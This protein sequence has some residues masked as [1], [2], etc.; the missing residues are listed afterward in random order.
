MQSPCEFE[1]TILT[2][3]LDHAVTSIASGTLHN[4]ATTTSG[5]ILSWGSTLD[6]ALGLGDPRRLSPGSP[7]G[8]DNDEELRIARRNYQYDPPP[9]VEIPTE[10]KFDFG[11]PGGP[12]KF[13]FGIG[14][15]G[16]HSAALVFDLSDR[17]DAQCEVDAPDWDGSEW[18]RSRIFV[19]SRNAV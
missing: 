8:F 10:I 11:Q 5:K 17:D 19:P 1:Q 3:L 14:A 9:D 18:A 16:R 4:I 6:G 12:E 13:V 2:P 7:G 15:G